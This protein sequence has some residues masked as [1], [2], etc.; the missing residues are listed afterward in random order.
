LEVFDL[1]VSGGHTDEQAAKIMG[2][3]LSN[4]KRYKKSAMEKF[5]AYQ[6]M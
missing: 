4:Y 1:A 5:E 3:S 6:A 2:F